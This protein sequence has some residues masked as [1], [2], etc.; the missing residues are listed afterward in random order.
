MHTREIVHTDL[1][2]DNIMFDLGSEV[3]LGA[4]VEADPGRYYSPVSPEQS[5][6][7]Q[8][9]VSQP[10][11]LPSLAE[12]MERRYIITDFGRGK[13]FSSLARAFALLNYGTAQPTHLHTY[14]EIT[15]P[16]LRAPETILQGPW[17]E[18]VDIWTFGCL[19][20]TNPSSNFPFISPVQ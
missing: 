9:A 19:V 20:R 14:D 16:A 2:P 5:P 15:A 6:Q 10:L 1:K 3:D 18:K 17:D 8:V 7:A 4:L 11:P 12:A 13:S